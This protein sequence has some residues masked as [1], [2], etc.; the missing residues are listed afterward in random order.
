MLIG[1][2]YPNL[3]AQ[4]LQKSI[5]VLD[6]TA[7]NSESNDARLFSVEH[8]AKV[9]GIPFIK[10][11]DI[12][13]ATNYGMILTSLL[14][15]N[16]TFSDEERI[17]LESYVEEGGLL[18]A[19]RIEEEDF[20]PLFGISA[21]ESSNSRLAIHWDTSLMDASL[22]YINQPEERTLS[23]GRDTY[24]EIFKTVGYTTS[25]ANTLASFPDG[26]AAVIKNNLGEGE[27]VSIGLSWKEV[28][29]RNQLNRDFEAHRVSS[30][31]FEPTSDVLAL[32]IR[33]L[34][35]EHHPFTV[36]KNTSPGN[37]K[38]T[39]MITHD[40][41][42]QSAMDTLRAFVDY[43][44]LKNLRATYNMTVRYFDDALMGPFYLGGQSTFDY[45]LSLIH[46]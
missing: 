7:R 8:M 17:E 2:T 4:N 15:K 33:A 3:S 36:W 41:D 26:T 14:I 13:V 35:M 20:F 44:A 34:F 31:G 25:T 12:S 42:S 27:A 37:S 18:V 24:D 23:L 46:I 10:T 11:D 5:A 28:I 22:K 40:I 29:L 45:I 38:A 9:T 39:L 19:P 32:F 16:N 30:N 43:E 21:S 1:L 6:L